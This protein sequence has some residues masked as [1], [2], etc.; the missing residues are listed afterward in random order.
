M[1]YTK[2]F[3]YYYD[4]FKDK[5]SY[6][7]TLKKLL[8]I[9]KENNVKSILDVGCGTGKIDKL[10]KDKGYEVIGIDNS[11]EMIEHAKNNYKDI[12]INFYVKDAKDFKFNK[13][14]DAII[15]LDSVLT[16]LTK[17][18]D[19][20]KAIENIVN[21]MKKGSVLY[22]NAGFTEKLIPKG[23][24][25]NFSKKVKKGKHNYKKETSM[26]RKGNLLITEIKIS[27][28]NKK[29]IEEEHKHRI[30]SEKLVSKLLKNMNCEFEIKGNSEE[31][32]YRPMEVIAKKR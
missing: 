5:K 18:G 19:F 12:N 28:N 22:F 17:K 10:L 26:K 4:I 21:H 6:K 16:F 23:F 30:I 25:E 32:E 20:E 31:Q 11:E 9:L 8:P 29:V 24:K 27:E 3:V 14:F 2:D 7:E 15:A 13:K 1:A